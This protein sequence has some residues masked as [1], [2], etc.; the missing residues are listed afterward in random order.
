MR[1]RMTVE[2]IAA[3]ALNAASSRVSSAA[4]GVRRSA[5]P[6][7]GGDLVSLSEQAVRLLQAK[8]EHG[9]AIELARTAD[10]IAQSAIDL[11]A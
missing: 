5:E 7:P 4:D 8:H 6:D 11:I 10:E 9:A 3:Q 1:K 2:G